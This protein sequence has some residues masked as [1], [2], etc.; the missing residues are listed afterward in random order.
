MKTLGAKDEKNPN[1]CIAVL[2]PSYDRTDI[3]KT[4]LLGWLKAKGVDKVFVV[5]EASSRTIL[6]RYEEVIQKYKESGKIVYKLVLKRLGSIRARNI[7]LNMVANQGYKYIVIVDDDYFL[8]NKN[9]LDAMARDFELDDEIGAVGGKVIVSRRRMDPDFFLNLPINLADSL[10]MLIGYV[11][12]DIKHGPRYSEFLPPFFMIRR[13]ILDKM[14][15]YD[16]V[17]D[18]PTAFREESD[19]QLQIKRLGYKLLYDPRI[20]VVHLATEEG[21]N[22]PNISMG[23]RIYWKARNH[24]I[25]ILKWNKSI[26][27]R[28]W[29][30]ILSTLV[31][32][33][34]RPWYGFWILKGLQDGVHTFNTAQTDRK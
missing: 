5:A 9:C 25:F 23:K 2:I 8:P 19:F 15:R 29:H 34:Y 16:K 21:G 20:R 11:F 26:V 18:T 6:E 13:E 31:L 30:L 4:T 17:F 33:M 1:D 10:T 32:M 24:T 14:V 22:R 28:I 12:L 3:L 27:K 7:S